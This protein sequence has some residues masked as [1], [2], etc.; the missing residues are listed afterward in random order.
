[1]TNT[2]YTVS[3]INNIIRDTF[4][5]DYPAQ[6]GSLKASLSSVLI[7][8][9]NR[10]PKLFEEIMEFEMR[11]SEKIKEEEQERRGEDA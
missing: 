10:D 6:A 4:P 3:D 2:E 8:V 1:M 11:V 9:K 5:N 7:A